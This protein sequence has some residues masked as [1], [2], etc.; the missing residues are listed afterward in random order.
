MNNDGWGQLGAG[1]DDNRLAGRDLQHNRQTR[2]ADEGHV[3]VRIVTQ[4]RESGGPMK[5]QG[6][7]DR[8]DES[9]G[10][11][12][13]GHHKQSMGDRRHEM[14]GMEHH[15]HPMHAHMEEEK[16][17]HHEAM[18]H[19]KHHL[20]RHHGRHYNTQHGHEHHHGRG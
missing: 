14:E 1:K 8:M 9:L 18:E 3:P 12:H 13:R 15:H 4:T 20:E 7:K 5:H 17:R 19:H 2:T 11:R 10:E 16:H 6:L